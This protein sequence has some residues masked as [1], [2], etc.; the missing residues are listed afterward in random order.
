MH[1]F[2]FFVKNES[3]RGKCEKRRPVCL[4]SS[5][6]CYSSALYTRKRKIELYSQKLIVM[7]HRVLCGYF[8]SMMSRLLVENLSRSVRI[9]PRLNSDTTNCNTFDP[10]SFQVHGKR[11]VH[12]GDLSEICSKCKSQSPHIAESLQSNCYEHLKIYCSMI[13]QLLSF[14]S[15]LD[16]S[17]Y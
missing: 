17:G 7:P 10:D 2:G 15:V 16:R 9:C 1:S 4:F 5:F 13:Q 12:V 8:C 3:F 6:T 11:I 14:L